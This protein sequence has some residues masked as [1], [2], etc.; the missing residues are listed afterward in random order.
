MNSKPRTAYQFLYDNAQPVIRNEAAA[1]LFMS[2][3]N[4]M[5]NLEIISFLV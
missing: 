2:L 1:A 4:I 3:N 5:E